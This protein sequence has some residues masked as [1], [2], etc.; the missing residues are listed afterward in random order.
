MIHSNHETHCAVTCKAVIRQLLL[1]NVP[2]SA[3]PSTVVS[4][5]VCGWGK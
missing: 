4:G 1:N 5:K 2:D 3:N